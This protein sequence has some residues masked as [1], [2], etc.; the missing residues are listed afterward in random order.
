MV[1]VTFWSL[2]WRLL[3]TVERAAKRA[4]VKCNQ[5]KI[6]LK[7]MLELRFIVGKTLYEINDFLTK[8][9]RS[10]S[11]QSAAA[12]DRV[13]NKCRSDDRQVKAIFPTPIEPKWG[14]C[15]SILAAGCQNICFSER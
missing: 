2:F 7:A 12:H 3:A 15:I 9:C 11:R 1:R 13:E 8:S 14:F 4:K 5:G 10:F 6:G